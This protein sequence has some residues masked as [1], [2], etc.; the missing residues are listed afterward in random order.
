LFLQR[1]HK[2]RPCW[3]VGGLGQRLV[4]LDG[5][6]KDAVM[7]AFT[8]SLINDTDTMHSVERVQNSA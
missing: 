2:G 8:E 7:V 6:E 5:K 1:L 4:F 3:G